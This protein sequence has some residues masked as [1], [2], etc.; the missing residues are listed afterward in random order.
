[1]KKSVAVQEVKKLVN[2]CGFLPE[3]VFTEYNA[4]MLLFHLEQMGFLPPKSEPTYHESTGKQLQTTNTW[5][6]E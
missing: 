2:T 4:E 5:D 1:M 6:K 3:G